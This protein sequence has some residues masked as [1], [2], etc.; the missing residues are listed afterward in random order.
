MSD[1]KVLL[2]ESIEKGEFSTVKRI[3]S[4]NPTLIRSPKLPDENPS[5]RPMTVA[6][7]NC[8]VEILAFLIDQGGEVMEHSNFPLC[9]TATRGGCVPTM[10]LL[11]NHGADVDQVCQDYGPPIIYAVEGSSLDSIAFLLDNG[12]KIAGVGAGSEEPVSWDALKHAGHFN[13]KTPDLIPL[14]LKHG[15]EIN[16]DI[17][18]QKG[19]KDHNTALHNVAQKGDIE[20]IKLLLKHGADLNATNNKGQKPVEMSRNLKVR[21]LLELGATPNAESNEKNDL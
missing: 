11:V 13:R 3:I 10:E 1:D 9:R 6:S 8:Q 14:L 7:V 12:A 21:E 2:N 5:F 16:N 17:V 19:G 15:A 4:A 20:G 18:D